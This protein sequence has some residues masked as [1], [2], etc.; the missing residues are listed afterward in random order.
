MA[1][2]ILDHL[3]VSGADWEKVAALYSEEWPTRTGT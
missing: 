2:L 3:P 1:E